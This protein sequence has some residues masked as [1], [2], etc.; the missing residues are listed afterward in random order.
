MS[1]FFS[2]LKTGDAIPTYKYFVGGEW[3]TS[4]SGR[5]LEVRSPI[6]GSLVGRIQACTKEEAAAVIENAAKSWQAWNDL[7]VSRRADILHKVDDLIFEHKDELINLLMMEIGKNYAS[8][9]EEVVRT[10]ELIHYFNEEGRRFYGEII[11][12]DSF[13]A[14]SKDKICLVY[15]EPYGVI[16]CIGPFNYPL[17]LSASKIA[18]ALITGNSAVF[19]PPLQGAIS[20][21]FMT[22]IFRQGGVPSGVLNTIT[23]SPSEIGD[24]LASH[25]QVAMLSFTGSTKTGK[26]LAH[27][28]GPKKM[29]LELG[30]KDAA[31]VLKDADLELTTKQIVKGAFSYSGQRCTAMKRVLPVPEIADRLV[32]MIVE[33]VKKLKV[34]DPRE[35][36]VF[37]GPVISD[38]S[39]D[40]VQGLIDDAIA[41]GAKVLCGNKRDGRLLWPTVLDNVTLDMRVAWEEPFGPVLPI[42]RV[43]NIDEAIEIANRSEYGLQSAVFTQDI[44]AAFYVGKKLEVGTVNVNGADSRGPDHFPFLGVKNSGMETQ[45][46]HYS[47]EAMTRTKAITLN[48]RNPRG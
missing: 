6:D 7:T 45:G 20:C 10:A 33:S 31:I 47:I 38:A 15:R 48:L 9:E 34:G 44:D 22:E 4:T 18:P 27:T 25:P 30:G 42:I 40:Y 1:D 14:Y 28:A 46:V 12:G 5:T 21:L 13:P 24:A 43:K 2:D 23:G 35:K 17:N 39:A 26:H 36:D 41:N 19:K 29:M 16:L 8:A 37:I 3:K 32:E 11:W